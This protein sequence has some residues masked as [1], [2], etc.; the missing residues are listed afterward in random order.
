MKRGLAARLGFTALRRGIAPPRLSSLERYRE[1]WF[2]KRIL[3]KLKITVVLD[4][5]ANDGKFAEGLRLLG[6]RGRIASFEPIPSEIEKLRRRAHGDVDWRVFDYALGSETG[7]ADF[8]VI[9]EGGGHFYSSFLK[10]AAA[11][12]VSTVLRIAV[13]RLDSIWR[14]I[15]RLED[16]VF[17][18][19]D[20]QG[21]DMRVLQGTGEYLK[22]VLGVMAEANVERLYEGA[23][24][25]LET[26]AFLEAQG[27]SLMDLRVI[28]RT[29][30][31]SV[32]EYDCIMARI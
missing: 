14:E 31:G 1:Q 25:Y 24:H 8:N 2:L 28:D 20:T 15:I 10:P 27:F 26:L 7:M 4:I 16:R 22:N 18:K 11:P 12:P 21:F 9:E 17:L 6:Y 23:P 19:T 30:Q 5:G 3:E 13:R 29:A 32:L